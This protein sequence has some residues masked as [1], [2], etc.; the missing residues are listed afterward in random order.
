MHLLFS[1]LATLSHFLQYPP[2]LQAMI[3]G[4]VVEPVMDAVWPWEW[5]SESERT[6]SVIDGL[7]LD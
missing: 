3:E 6:R 2:S 7:Q 1:F 4:S 5:R